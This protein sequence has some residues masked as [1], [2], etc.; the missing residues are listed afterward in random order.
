[1]STPTTIARPPLPLPTP[2]SIA[3]QRYR[4][5]LPREQEHLWN[6]SFDTACSMQDIIATIRNVENEA[7][8]RRSHKL[9]ERLQ[10]ISEPLRVSAPALDVLAQ[11]NS[12]AMVPVWG[13]LRLV[14]LLVKSHSDLLAKIANM[15]EDLIACLCRLRRYEEIFP[16][17]FHVQEAIIDVYSESIA[18]C[19]LI[20]SLYQ[21]TLAKKIVRP[22]FQSK[23]SFNFQ[24]TLS[25]L[26]KKLRAIDPV[27]LQEEIHES[28]T[29]RVANDS[30]R[31][32]V[33]DRWGKGDI[34]QEEARARLVRQWLRPTDYESRL[35]SLQ[36]SRLSGT[37]DWIFEAQEF[38]VWLS[39]STSPSS[40]LLLTGGP[41][42]GKS[43]LLS[44][45]ISDLRS[46]AEPVIFFFFKASD[47]SRSTILSM[48]KDLI[49]QLL[50]YSDDGIFRELFRIYEKCGRPMPSLAP[51]WKIFSSFARKMPK[52]ICFLDALDECVEDDKHLLLSNLTNMCQ[53]SNGSFKLLC[54]SR[55][56]AAIIKS[57]EVCGSVMNL[58]PKHLSMDI[59]RLISANINASHK[60]NHESVRKEVLGTL[61]TQAHGSFLWV[62]LMNSE[63]NRAPSIFE[64]K[65][66][67][68]TLPPGL[69]STYRQIFLR[70]RATL[71]SEQMDLACSVLQ[72]VI[73]AA[74]PMHNSEFDHAYAIQNS[75]S[76]AV[77][78]QDCLL[79]N[80]R[81]EILAACGSLVEIGSDG[82]LHLIHLSLREFLL[83]STADEEGL[84]GNK[85]FNKTSSSRMIAQASLDYLGLNVFQRKGTAH[86]VD[87]AVAAYP[88]FEYAALHWSQHIASSDEASS[89]D[90]ERV[91][92]FFHSPQAFFWLSYI[93]EKLGRSV[94]DLLLVQSHISAWTAKVRQPL[95]EETSTLIRSLYTRKLD[96][97]ITIHGRNHV[98]TARTV[99]NLGQ[100]LLSLGKSEEASKHL[101]DALQGISKET[102]SQLE[103]L[104][105][106]SELGSVK[107]A[108]GR[109]AEAEELYR[110]VLVGYIDLVGADHIET[111]T[112][113][114]RLAHVLSC[115]GK[116]VEAKD[117]IIQVC[118][119]REM[120]LGKYHPETLDSLHELAMT[121]EGLGLYQEFKSAAEKV[122][123]LRERILGQDHPDT[124]RSRAA[125]AFALKGNN[126][127]EQAYYHYEETMNK[128]IQ[129]LGERH[130]DTQTCMMD[131]AIIKQEQGNLEASRV[132]DLRLLKIRAKEQ[133]PKHPGTLTLQHH[134]AYVLQQQGRFHKAERIN[135]KVQ[136][137]QQETLG[138]DH[139]HT[140]FSMCDL[141]VVLRFQNKLEDAIFWS[142]KSYI[143]RKH[144]LGELHRE[145][146]HSAYE[147][148]LNLLYSSRL[149]DAEHLLELAA[150]S[151]RD[152]FGEKHSVTLQSQDSLG[153][154]SQ[155]RCD[156]TKS[157]DLHQEVLGV[158][159]SESEKS[160]HPDLG[161]SYL[162]LGCLSLSQCQYQI[163]E[164]YF[165]KG[166]LLL[167]RS[168]KGNHDALL[169]KYFK[170]IAARRRLIVTMTDLPWL[171]YFTVVF[172]SIVLLV[173]GMYRSW[174]TRSDA[175][176][177]ILCRVPGP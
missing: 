156:Y 86:D 164:D 26:E 123:L 21:D 97:S 127:L 48:L 83:S 102:N 90:L 64:L 93:T 72:Y 70:M 50:E 121:Y 124:L 7:F 33:R 29:D 130:P 15:I 172:F 103:S 66:K 115:R 36:A 177:R 24:S 98:E 4:N 176:R 128:R 78:N 170:T 23:A 143:S 28:K 140:L 126:F 129:V 75:P 22:L 5:Q 77:L 131:M 61:S 137:I 25:R 109:Y 139:P 13:P 17:S 165:E 3:F 152:F 133:G 85:I 101:N 44:S 41:G 42:C 49:F 107:I 167:G 118:S 110:Q 116:L 1:M 8:R 82:K 55:S 51:L 171:K 125:F 47:E 145:T 65:R 71:S 60:L 88:F 27:A 168:E 46:K 112:T 89:K 158:R 147:L 2:F 87:D 96:I 52:L 19:V 74:R 59:N 81:E 39:G 57:L 149:E 163:A 32:D 113:Y 111:L 175:R 100:L 120:I 114:A 56:D 157:H 173:V 68:R 54:T 154:L 146:I 148:G 142:R 10:R 162:Y 67:L 35:E 104:G 153:L 73:F 141:G 79:F 45:V 53:S 95:K 169:A 62:V 161:Q 43:V 20:V 31:Q 9:F 92:Q 108:Q 84:F 151:R 18:F 136:R 14:I 91:K 12:G 99:R 155:A 11:V 69:H 58:T 16:T 122:Y 76:K 174:V 94:K 150:R 138:P 34:H 166:S 135:R 159:I 160:P 37:C 144:T 105:V 63:L 117:I 119:G 134:L 40:S 106:Q 38:L 6:S 132:M 80:C 30:F